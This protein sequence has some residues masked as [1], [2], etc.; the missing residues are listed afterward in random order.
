MDNREYKKDMEK[1]HKDQDKFKK[2]KRKFRK[3]AGFGILILALAMLIAYF[4]GFNMGTGDGSDGLIGSLLGTSSES[5]SD[6][7]NDDTRQ[8]DQ[9]NETDT[10]HKNLP[11]VIVDENDIIYKG[12]SITEDLLRQRLE[13]DG[14]TEV[15]LVDRASFYQTYQNI[16]EL[17]TDMG[18][19]YTESR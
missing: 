1:L 9:T 3:R 13:E 16:E 2:K 14:V 4:F 19:T 5:T 7:D 10:T 6:E 8:A 12:D 11:E 15:I 17:L 18:I